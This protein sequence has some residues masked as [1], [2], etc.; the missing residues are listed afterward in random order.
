MDVAFDDLNEFVIYMNLENII[1][2]CFQFYKHN[3]NITAGESLGL[4]TCSSALNLFL[5]MIF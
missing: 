2:C 4:I 5:S 3:I 1:S